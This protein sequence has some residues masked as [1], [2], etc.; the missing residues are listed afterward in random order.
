MCGRFAL[1]IPPFNIVEYFNIDELIDYE[2]R[3]NIAPT[4]SVPVIVNNRENNKRVMKL[5]RWGLI[6]SWAKAPGIGSKLINARA[7]TAAEKPSFRSAFKHRRCLIPATGF[8]EWG[9]TDSAKQPYFIRRQDTKPLAFAGLWERWHGTGDSNIDS[10]TILTTE[11]NDVLSTLHNRMPVI[12]DPD[13]YELW[14]NTDMTDKARLKHLMKP[15]QSEPL[16]VYP[17]STYVNK[18][19]N[20]DLKCIEPYR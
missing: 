8:Y 14:L 3:Y 12:L 20:D 15:Y 9:K 5:Y 6:P 16:T 18:P 7:E 17:V 11:A 13:A 1:G 10:C 4:Q 19:Q 2:P